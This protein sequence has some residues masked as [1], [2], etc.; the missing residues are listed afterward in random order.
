MVWPRNTRLAQGYEPSNN[1][2]T[3]RR[4]NSGKLILILANTEFNEHHLRL[5]LYSIDSRVLYK[6]HFVV[7]FLY[8]ASI[9]VPILKGNLL[10]YYNYKCEE[11]IW[12][13]NRLMMTA[14]A[15]TRSM[16]C[17]SKMS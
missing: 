11:H 16:D 7:C 1:G 9:T 17:T 8:L 5:I 12:L 2:T 10:L 4:R 13:G 3:V 6:L 14:T 15:G